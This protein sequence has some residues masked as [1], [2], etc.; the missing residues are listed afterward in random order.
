MVVAPNPVATG[1]PFIVTITAANTDSTG[2]TYSGGIRWEVTE[3]SIGIISVEC[4]EGFTSN[5][6]V[7]AEC[8]GTIG[9]GRTVTMTV[10]A[11]VDEAGT[12][13]DSATVWPTPD[14]TP[15]DDTLAGTFTSVGTEP[16]EEGESVSKRGGEPGGSPGAGEPSPTAAPHIA[17]LVIAP[18]RFHAASKGAT[19]SRVSGARS[20]RATPTG[21][22][23]SYAVDQNATAR[24]GVLRGANGRSVGG[25]CLAPTH[26][27][28]RKPRCVRYLAVPGTVAVNA[29]EGTDHL[30][31]SGR[32]G[33]RKLGPGGYE[34]TLQ[35]TSASG[36]TSAS[37]R[38][39][40]HIV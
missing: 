27:S 12:Y 1:I 39:S 33:G 3:A 22:L 4:P 21:A 19:F 18:A 8:L 11:S 37:K 23:V 20:A 24:F 6:G 36:K 26:S 7:G 15:P 34:L 35:A 40:F 16:T 32:W 13:N 17:S 25:R 14:V 31:F 28:Q 5:P 29:V 10:T 30:R 9:P 38:V 2:P